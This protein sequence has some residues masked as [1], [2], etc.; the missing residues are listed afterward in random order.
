MPHC[1]T[2]H[3]GECVYQGE[4]RIVAYTA[5]T[6]IDS[7]IM[8]T[9]RADTDRKISKVITFIGCTLTGR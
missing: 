4:G 2:K 6:K 9:A 3:G 8:P 1:Y 5:F 7:N